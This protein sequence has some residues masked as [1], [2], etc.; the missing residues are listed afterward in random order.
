M[1]EEIWKPKHNNKY[2]KMTEFFLNKAVIRHMWYRKNALSVLGTNISYA[3][4]IRILV[5]EP[6]SN[7]EATTY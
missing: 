2:T 5:G 7:N 1:N 3:K 4:V 6:V